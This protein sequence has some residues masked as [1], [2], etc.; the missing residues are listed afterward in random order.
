MAS[1]LMNVSITPELERYVEEQ[2]GSGAYKTKSDVVRDS[3]RL[4]REREQKIA[5]L[6]ARIQKSLDSGPAKPWDVDAFRIKARER[7]AELRANERTA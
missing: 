1:T 7:M 3:L 2:V 5:E 6:R 4:H